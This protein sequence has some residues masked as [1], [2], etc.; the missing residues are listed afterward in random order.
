MSNSIQAKKH[1]ELGKMFIQQGS[2]DLAIEEYKR[3]LIYGSTYPDIH[4]HLGVAYEYKGD[5]D[6]AVLH[7]QKALSL[8]PK[9]LDA[10]LHLG[11]TYVKTKSWD[12][13]MVK[14]KEVLSIDANSA[15]AY[16]YLGEIAYKRSKSGLSS[17]EE[18]IEMHKK[19]IELNPKYLDAYVSLGRAYREKGDIAEA[20]KYFKK[21]DELRVSSRG[22]NA[23]RD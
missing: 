18:A 22:N 19:A 11:I 23:G 2:L 15:E 20:N 6:K 13:A 5:Y 7:F 16:H 17:V 4:F 10:N 8:N 14:L 9:Y 21:A 12:K 3:A 1:F